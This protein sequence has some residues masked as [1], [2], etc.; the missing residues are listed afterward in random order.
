MLFLICIFLSLVKSEH[1]YKHSLR[2]IPEKMRQ[3]HIQQTAQFVFLEIQTKM[4]ID[5]SENRTET[6]FTL[7]CLEPNLEQ[8]RYRLLLPYEIRLYVQP[9]YPKTECNVKEGYELYSRYKTKLMDEPHVY[10]ENFFHLLNDEFPYLRH[11]LSSETR[12]SG[13]FDTECCPV[14]TVS[15]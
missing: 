9:I 11:S 6:N 3:E 7:F 13:L 14:Y 12:G 5:A 8:E 15:W 4:L 2:H 1:S 10:I